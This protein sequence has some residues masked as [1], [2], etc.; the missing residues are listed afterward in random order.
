MS[1]ESGPAITKRRHDSCGGIV[2]KVG[3]DDKPFCSTC[4]EVVNR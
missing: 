2:Y 4:K 1:K 3:S